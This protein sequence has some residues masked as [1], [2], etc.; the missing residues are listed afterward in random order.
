MHLQHFGLGSEPF[1]A[2]FQTSFFYRGFQHG[3]A[4][5]FLEQ[6]FSIGRPAMAL[7][8]PRGTGKSAS[9]RFAV[10]RRRGGGRLG[11]IDGLAAEPTAFLIDVLAAFGFGSIEAGH[12]E[13]RNLLSVFVVQARQNGQHVL[14]QI[15]DPNMPTPDV[16]DEILWLVR[17]VAGDASFQLV[18]SGGDA[19][20]RMLASPRLSAIA[21]ECRDRH[22]LGPLDEP[23]TIDYLHFRLAAAGAADPAR[24]LPD[25]AARAIHEAAGGVVKE[26]NRLAA[27]VLERCGRARAACVDTDAVRQGAV[28]LGLARPNGEETGTY[29]LDVR[30]DDLPYMSLPLGGSKV[31][32]GRH[33]HNEIHLRDGSV[34]RYHAMVVPEGDRWAVVDLNSTNGT[35]VNG[36]AVQHRPLTAG[37]QVGVGRFTIEFSGLGAASGAAEEPD[38]R[39]TVVL[40]QDRPPGVAARGRR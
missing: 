38:F 40:D 20:E 35:R 26:I 12:A 34:S 29:R 7:L 14:L 6:G 22:R 16:A 18:F 25:G 31:L 23:E 15:R 39:R 32:I 13:L 3:A 8:G 17:N 21:G 2:A 19:L 9:L 4:L 5:T 1:A 10:E 36:E 30:L 24:V 11:Q 27:A 33:S 37:D 28:D